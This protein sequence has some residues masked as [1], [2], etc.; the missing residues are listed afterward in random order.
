MILLKIL[1]DVE[2]AYKDVERTCDGRDYPQTF[3]SRTHLRNNAAKRA[4]HVLRKY[5]LARDHELFKCDTCGQGFGTG[6]GLMTHERKKHPEPKLTTGYNPL[7]V[8]MHVEKDA[9]R[10]ACAVMVC[11]V[12]KR[13]VNTYLHNL[14]GLPYS[15]ETL[16]RI[17]SCCDALRKRVIVDFDCMVIP[18][19]LTF[20]VVLIYLALNR[21]GWTQ[22]DVAK[23][24]RI[25][26]VTLRNNLKRLVSKHPDK[27]IA[28]R[29]LIDDALVGIPKLDNTNFG[30][31]HILKW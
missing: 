26:E 25:R 4:A 5:L 3:F 16:S 2:E 19:R 30:N 1:A 7:N 13:A 10:S 11:D 29:G 15:E 8:D 18:N 24:A 9:S 21:L 28:L 22:I 14:P 6:V 20:A 12:V 27:I 31:T 17:E 23:A